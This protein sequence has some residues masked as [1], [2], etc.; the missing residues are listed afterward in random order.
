MEAYLKTTA[1]AGVT[2]AH[3]AGRVPTASIAAAARALASNQ[4]LVSSSSKFGS[5]H[6]LAMS[7]QAAA[8]P[9]MKRINSKLPGY[10]KY[11][12]E[13]GGLGGSAKDVLKAFA[14]VTSA[15]ASPKQ[16]ATERAL[17]QSISMVMNIE[18]SSSTSSRA[19][20]SDVASPLARSLK[21]RRMPLEGKWTK[22][23]HG[24][25][26]ILIKVSVVLSLTTVQPLIVR[27]ARY[28][29]DLSQVQDRTHGQRLHPCDRAYSYKL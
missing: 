13:G 14:P 28:K 10:Q 9:R 4:G 19:V 17:V 12:A 1:S 7:A 22:R 11:L 8:S 2:A 18:E 27:V 21:P 26:Q 23:C 24:C 6:N 16:G 20:L 25:R 15:V 3:A 29:G 5:L